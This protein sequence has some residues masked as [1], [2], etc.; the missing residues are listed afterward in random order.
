MINNRILKGILNE[1]VSDFQLA[2]D[3]EFKS[4]E[5]LVNYVVL[6]KID[7]DAFSDMEAFDQVDAE[8]PENEK[9]TGNKLDLVDVDKVDKKGRQQG[10]YGVD[11]FALFINNS[12]ITKKEDIKLHNRTKRLDVKFVFIQTKASPSFDLG[13]LLKLIDAVNEFLSADSPTEVSEGLCVAKE[14]FD[15][16][17]KRENSRLFAGSKPQCELYFAT[18]GVKCE[19]EFIQRKLAE[20]EANLKKL[21]PDI[22]QFSIKLIDADYIIDSYSEIENTYRVVIDL[23]NKV[24]CKKIDNV[25]QSFIGYLTA[26]DFLKL[27]TGS[28]G[29]IRKNLFYENVRDFQGA[30]NNVNKE[31]NDT[32]NTP[33]LV[34]KFILL[35]NGVTIIARDF[36]NIRS[37]EYELSDYFIVNGC[38]TSNIIYLN[39]SVVSCHPNFSVPVK[40]IHTIDNEFISTLIRST[41]RQTPVPDEAFVSL[42]KFHKRL[43]EYYSRF[44]EI[45]SEK[46]Y[47]ERRSREFANTE[48]RI[49]RPRI[50]S[51]HAVI[52]SFT[53][54]IL[55][56]PQLVASQHPSTILK[57]HRSKLF[58]EGHKFTPY[59]L[60]SMLLFLFYKL[61]KQ[62]EIHEKYALSKYWISWIV[63][64]LASGTPKYPQLNSQEC[65]KLYENIIK[66]LSNLDYTRSLYARS[67]SLFEK[68][69]ADHQTNNGY[70]KNRELIRLKS[71]QKV[72]SSHIESEL[73]QSKNAHG[74]GRKR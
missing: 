1:F 12:L 58:V 8:S 23:E 45:A 42:E 47:Y 55:G 61:Q 7:P 26:P 53:A 29:N 33:E 34:D 38:Q 46:L 11:A 64:S 36:N 6:S 74:R 72:V 14:L 39:R 41:N 31:I 9:K 16:V 30:E 20:S 32:L 50:V 54:V 70:K 35:N 4:Y 43:Q 57:E 13:A 28:D 27:I 15:E 21:N 49:E 37:N 66:N 62:Q 67:I 5:R 18:S 63:C 68:S 40:I 44:S 51:L 59:Y 17:F 2:N 71:F 52:R 48:N 22:S 10:T 60:S 73:K 24:A 3:D 69:R 19:D 25:E 65:E 56:E